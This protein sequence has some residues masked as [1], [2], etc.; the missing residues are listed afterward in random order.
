MDAEAKGLEASLHQLL[1][2]HHH[3]SLILAHHTEKAKKDAIRKAERVSDLLVEAVNGGVQDSFINQK[4]IELEIRTLSA[5][6]TRFM[7]Q[8]DQWLAATHALNT[9]LK[10]SSCNKL[11]LDNLV[12]L[13]EL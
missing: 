4:R 12:F 10:L 5:T 11:D 3:N 13:L 2:R 9:A 7:K 6:I 1:H 8:T